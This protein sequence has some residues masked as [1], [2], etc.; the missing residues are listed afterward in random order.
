MMVNGQLR[1][2][3]LLLIERDDDNRR[4]LAKL[5]AG[6]FEVVVAAGSDLAFAILR[7]PATFDLILLDLMLPQKDGWEFRVA[8]R[9]DKVLSL[10]PVIAM[11][12]N[13]SAQERAI[14]ADAYVPKPFEPAAMLA[15]IRHVL[16]QRRL[17][18]LDR[19]ASLGTMA[20]GIAHEVNNPLTY[21]HGNLTVIQRDLASM[22]AK[23]GPDARA[24]VARAKIAV[25]KAIEGVDRIRSIMGGV[26][27]FSRAPDDERM[28]VDLRTVIESSLM[29]IAHEVERKATVE[30]DLGEIPLMLGNPG[31]LGQ[32]VVNLISNAADSISVDTPSPL[33]IV[34]RTYTSDSGE[35]VLEVKDTGCGMRESVRAKIFD[36]FFT[37]KAPGA[38]T[39]LGLSICHGIVRGHEGAIGVE[40]TLGKGTAFRVVF[41]PSRPALAASTSS[42][43][44]V[45]GRLLIIEDNEHVGDA[46]ADM[47]GPD[48]EATVVVGDAGRATALLEEEGPTF[49][50]IL[51][52][53]QLGRTTGKQ[54]YERLRQSRPELVGRIV[55][56][57]GLAVTGPV[58]QFLAEI[59]NPCLQK[60]FDVD[61]FRKAVSALPKRARRVSG[62]RIKLASLEAVAQLAE[63]KGVRTKRS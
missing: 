43:S 31:Q 27:L 28:P 29:I 12:V 14:D 23:A 18:H 13:T 61:E 6:E 44:T 22:H 60:V 56:M 41:P 35:I 21:V 63:A 10:I 34:V 11:S 25:G 57:T 42:A 20:A 53:I 45:E 48:Y 2:P 16:D 47:L 24:T 40:S 17:M 51:C 26:R 55:F 62:V 8:Q 19:L 39:G 9:A 30:R 59:S 15:A 50:V 37:T 46:L 38:G 5:L 52:D 7:G 49:D 4:Q 36:P 3:R 33:R 58:R 32:L 54:I 1:R